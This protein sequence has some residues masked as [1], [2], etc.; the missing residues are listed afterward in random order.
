M[1]FMLACYWLTGR[2]LEHVATP[3]VED[4]V[5]C[6]KR[7]RVVVEKP[8]ASEQHETHCRDKIHRAS[9]HNRGLFV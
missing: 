7:H 2:R 3:A 5:F 9:F 4:K 1:T 6:R 8:A